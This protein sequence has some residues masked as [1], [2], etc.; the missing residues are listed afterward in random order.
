MP[1]LE[2]TLIERMQ[3][4]GSVAGLQH[5]RSAFNQALDTHKTFQKKGSDVSKDNRL[6]PV[7]RKEKLQEYV[8]KEA[9]QVVRAR[10]TLAR[11]KEKHAAKYASLQPKSPDKTDVVA[12][13]ARSDLRSM[14]RGMP[15]GKSMQILLADD[16]DPMLLAAVLELPN[17]ASGINDETRRMVTERVIERDH[18]GALA[19]LERDAEAIDLLDVAVRVAAGTARDIGEFPNDRLFD[20]FIEKSVGDTARLDV[21]IDHSLCEAVS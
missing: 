3:R 18:P 13:V 6:T 12:A 14:L 1:T 16:A 9:H 4:F 21:D 5:V 10:R 15:I 2:E 8:G 19:D 20:D 7:G 17:Y 11:I